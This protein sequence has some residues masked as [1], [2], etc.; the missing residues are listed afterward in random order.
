MD[1][2][3]IVKSKEGR[4][5]YILNYKKSNEKETIVCVTKHN[6]DLYVE[7]RDV[8]NI[9]EYKIISATMYRK[10]DMTGVKHFKQ[11]VGDSGTHEYNSQFIRVDNIRKWLS[12]STK[13]EAKP[14]LKFINSQVITNKEI[15]EDFTNFTDAVT[16]ITGEKDYTI[17]PP[18]PTINSDTMIE[19]ILGDSRVKNL[20]VQIVEEYLNN[21]GEI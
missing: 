19:K 3:K 15:F 12:G 21:K 2:L 8:I 4:V 9:T 5:F 20:L 13:S 1:I 14:L 7:F 17:D 16:N 6:G 10:M 18:A 11:P